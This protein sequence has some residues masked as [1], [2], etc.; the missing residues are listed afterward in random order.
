MLIA[1]LDTH[2]TSRF[3]T[4]TENCSVRDTADI[5][6]DG[7][8]G[9]VIVCDLG[10]LAVGVVSKSDLVRHLAQGRDGE[11]PVREVMTRS[12]IA[13]SPDNELKTAWELMAKRRLQ[14][15]PLIGPNRRPIGT[16]DIRDALQALIDLEQD[17]ER[18]LVNYIAGVGYR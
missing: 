2:T 6:S 4:T 5:F 18:Q 11:R 14:N 9:L 17:Q 16:L 12:V 7:R 1:D 3:R 15:L 8:L 13:A 10:G